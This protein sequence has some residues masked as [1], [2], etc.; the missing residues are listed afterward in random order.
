MDHICFRDLDL[1]LS[2][3]A[4]AVLLTVLGLSGS[5]LAETEDEKR[6]VVWLLEHDQSALGLGTVDIGLSE[7]PW[8]RERF[9]EEQDFLLRVIGGAKARLGWEALDYRPDE[10]RLGAWLERLEAMVRTASP[11]DIEEG[12]AQAWLAAAESGD[13]VRKGFPRCPR[14]GIFLTLFGCL[15]CNDA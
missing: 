1:A 14:H 4:L 13:P 2:N 6:L 7:L 11:G 5:R 10:A 3:G 15:A 12:A 8:V 9:A